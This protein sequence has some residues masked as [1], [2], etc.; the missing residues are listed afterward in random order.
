MSARD[1]D[2][3]ESG[4]FG[5]DAERTLRLRAKDELRRR[6]RTVRGAVPA[7]ARAARA[8]ALADRVFAL[9]EYARARVVAAY[10]AVQSE[11]DPAAVLA[12]A[13]AEQKH[14]ALPRIMEDG[15]LEFRD[16]SD[17]RTLVESPLGIPEPPNEALL[18]RPDEIDFVL[19]PALAVDARGHRIGSGRGYY[20]RVL[21]ALT[22]AH[23]VAFVYDFQLLAEI[24]D[25]EGDVRVD[26][27][28]TD[29]RTLV[30]GA[31]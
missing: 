5:R 10:V 15:A 11:A 18:V 28:V 30:A 14:V 27:I 16:W 9:D 3:D 23:K 2:R 25:T 8:R 12:R 22:R 13:L 29:R 20:D 21:P 4:R 19:V 6:M 24:P 1:D 26:R 7:D 17:R 31:A